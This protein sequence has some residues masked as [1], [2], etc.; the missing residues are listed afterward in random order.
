AAARAE[1]AL[2]TLSRTESDM[3]ALEASQNAMTLTEQA[4]GDAG[5]LLQQGREVMVAAGNASYSAGE[6]K[7]LAVRLDGI[8]TQL[9][10]IANRTDETGNY[11][12]FPSWSGPGVPMVDGGPGVGVSTS[13]GASTERLTAAREQ[14]PINVDGR[15]AWRVDPGTGESALFKGLD[16]AVAELK[17]DTPSLTPTQIAAA[18]LTSADE[19]FTTLNLLR[20]RV[21]ELLNR[22]DAIGGRLADLRLFAQTERS[23]AEDLDMVQAIS[24]FQGRQTSYDAALKTYSMVQRMSLFD[25]IKT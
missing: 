25:Y 1:R 3:R 6:R 8:R 19:S 10:A 17:S 11:L 9:L 22:G 23:S 2:V 21:G 20:A 7:A 14:M 15:A 12:F 5:E 18:G 24:E 13:A 4:L 16:D